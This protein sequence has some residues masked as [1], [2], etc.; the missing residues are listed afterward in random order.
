M[1]AQ[2]VTQKMVEEWLEK[3]RPNLTTYSSHNGNKGVYR[4]DL[5][6]AYDFSAIGST[7][8]EVLENLKA[9]A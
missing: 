7:W 4:R 6:P 5:G 1:G 3:H 8:R 9:Q 2:R